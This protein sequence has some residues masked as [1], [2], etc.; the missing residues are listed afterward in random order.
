MIELA[1]E[2]FEPMRYESGSNL[3]IRWPSPAGRMAPR[4]IQ[5]ARKRLVSFARAVG[6]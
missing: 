2:M 5:F 1:V 4:S 6:L 3:M